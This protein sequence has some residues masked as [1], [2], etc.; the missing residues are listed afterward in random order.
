MLPYLPMAK[1]NSLC[2]IIMSNQ[3]QAFEVASN[4][5]G[6]TASVTMCA[7]CG[8]R[9]FEPIRYNNHLAKPDPL[10]IL[11]AKA[12]YN[13]LPIDYLK[14]RLM[15]RDGYIRRCLEC[16]HGHFAKKITDEELANYYKQVYRGSNYAVDTDFVTDTSVSQCKFIEKYVDQITNVLEIGGGA[17]EAMRY[18]QNGHSKIQLSVVEPSPYFDNYYNHVGINKIAD[19]FPVGSNRW[20]GTF[21]YI[22]TSHWIEHVYD[23][24][25]SVE[26][27][28]KLLCEDG[29]LYVETP[30]SPEICFKL[31]W[32]DAPHI[33]FFTK[34][35]LKKLLEAHSFQVLDIVELSFTHEEELQ[36]KQGL[37]SAEKVQQIHQQY[38]DS[39][40]RASGQ[41]LRCI[42]KKCS[43]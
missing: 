35:S 23:A 20:D 21:D 14:Y 6:E 16:G 30:N 40:N 12:V 10:K 34:K 43:S 29:L 36:R 17:C 41:Y 18:L 42:A 27:L 1:E 4:Q 19:M 2:E 32:P 15:F 39:E 9:C 26:A 25:K 7:M 24:H 31:D 13:F 11:V 8:E 38:L 33:H 28:N 37:L 5:C 22:H 3:K